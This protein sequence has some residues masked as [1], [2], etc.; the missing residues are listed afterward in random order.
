MQNSIRD[1]ELQKEII[2]EFKTREDNK[3][4]HEEWAKRYP[5]VYVC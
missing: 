3:K 2:E 4:R 5:K 1:K